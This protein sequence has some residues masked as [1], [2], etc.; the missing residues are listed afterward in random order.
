MD[1]QDNNIT[2]RDSINRANA[3]IASTVGAG[4]AAE[5]GEAVDGTG[6]TAESG[7]RASEKNDDGFGDGTRRMLAG[8]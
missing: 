5:G 3:G 4:A 8:Q 6:T 2:T 1:C 7:A